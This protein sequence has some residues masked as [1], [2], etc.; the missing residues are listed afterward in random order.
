MVLVFWKP[1]S[2]TEVS[3]APNVQLVGFESVEVKR[4]KTESVTVKVDV[5]KGLSVVDSERKRKLVTGEHTILV[6]SSTE[7]QVRHHFIVRLPAG[8]GDGGMVS[9]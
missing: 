6:G 8:S 2:S 5:C 7:H 4:G 3:G 1:A 9:L